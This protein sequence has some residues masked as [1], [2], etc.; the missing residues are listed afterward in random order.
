MLVRERAYD[1]FYAK[2]Q[3]KKKE[4]KNIEQTKNAEERATMYFWHSAPNVRI[5]TTHK[6]NYPIQLAILF[7]TLAIR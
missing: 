4:K 5:P 2:N 3:V 6:N 1:D 7:A